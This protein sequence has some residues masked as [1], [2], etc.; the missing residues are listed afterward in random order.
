[1]SARPVAAALIA[2]LLLT[3]CMTRPPAPVSERAPLSRPTE[4]A[5]PPV[6]APAPQR[7]ASPPPTYTVK[8]GDTLAQVALDNGLDYRD[9]AAWNNIENPNVI[10]PGQVLVLAA[11]GSSRPAPGWRR[12]RPA[13]Y[14]TTGGTQER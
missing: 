2:A 3:A 13:G 6:A 11:P 8:R 10:R 4:P 14:C 12:N 1:M 9:L 5:P 7:E